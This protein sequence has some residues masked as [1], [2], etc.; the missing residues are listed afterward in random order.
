MYIKHL[1]IENFKGHTYCEV[2]FAPG[3]NLLIG[4][5]GVGKTSILEA[6]SVALGG[7]LAG[8]PNVSSK[9]FTE[10]E[11]RIVETRT[12]E[13]S[14]ERQYKTPVVVTCVADINGIQYQ[15]TR[16]KSSRNAS[17]STVEPR[18][19]C[20]VASDMADRLE[21]TLPL[22]SYQSAARTW[23]QKRE[24]STN[25]F[26]QDFSRTV[27]YKNCLEEA[28]DSKSLLNWCAKMEQVA[29]QQDREI[30]EY[31]AV[32]NALSTFMSVMNDHHIS[33]IQFDKRN[34]ELSY[35]DNGISLPVRLLSAGYQS[36]IWMVLDIAYRMAVLNPNLLKDA[37]TSDGIVLIDELDMH[38]HPKWQWKVIEAL[39]TTF[40]NVQFIAATHS[41]ILIAACNGGRLIRISGDEISYGETDYGMEVNDVLTHT[42]G[43]QALAKDIKE[44]VDIVYAFLD[45]G[46][47]EE[48]EKE[49]LTLTQILGED[50]P[51]VTKAAVSLAFEKSFPEESE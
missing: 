38:L 26:D 35:V 7:Y 13:G 12:G 30:G 21:T 23:M 44:K 42:Q 8:I 25:I 28:S 49:L 33:K 6:A 14:F 17:R 9:H 20:S 51:A 16:R 27:G 11:I 19:I 2:D 50:H 40:P 48:A 41:P 31:E 47:T 46:K 34:M 5:N 37:T 36:L 15:W 1:T 39:Q 43:S 10:D 4:D 22:L 29:W 24:S 3:F 32:K 45:A 18:E